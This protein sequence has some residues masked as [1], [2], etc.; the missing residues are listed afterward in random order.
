MG[1]DRFH[2][3]SRL[4]LPRFGLPALIL[5][6]MRRAAFFGLVFTSGACSLLDWDALRGGENGGPTQDSGREDV[7]SREGG[8]SGADAESDAPPACNGDLDCERVVFTTSVPYEG[9][10]G[11]VGGGDAKCQALA[12]GSRLSSVR[13][14]RFVA[15]LGDADASALARVPQGTRRYRRPDG[16]VVQRNF[17]AFLSEPL[18]APIA[19]DEQG[20]LVDDAS[21]PSSQRAWGYAAP[22]DCLGWNSA[23]SANSGV[24]GLV[25]TTDTWNFSATQTCERPARLYCFEY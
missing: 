12:D 21:A 18:L 22:G 17:Q 20:G 24:F 7:D 4:R 9:N 23:S 6:R 8:G 5:A 14:R 2:L 11:G 10:L 19:V 3:Q 1:E 13:G 25:T 16:M 15:W